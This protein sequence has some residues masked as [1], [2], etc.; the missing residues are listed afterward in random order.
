MSNVP[1][2]IDPRDRVIS[3]TVALISLMLGV[4]PLSG[5]VFGLVRRSLHHQPG[6]PP[7]LALIFSAGFIGISVTILRGLRR[8]EVFHWLGGGPLNYLLPL[9]VIILAAMM[10]AESTTIAHLMVGRGMRPGVAKILSV[11]P[12]IAGGIVFAVCWRRALA[13]RL[14]P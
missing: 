14:R 6:M 13:A 5:F 2:P 10:N 9:L 1:V 3:I 7:I 11:L 4:L 12:I 8:G